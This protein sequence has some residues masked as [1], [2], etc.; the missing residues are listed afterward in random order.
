M[1]YYKRVLRSIRKPQIIII[2]TLTILGLIIRFYALGT[3]SVWYD[4][5]ITSIAARTLQTEGFPVLPSGAQY[6]RGILHTFF[7]ATSYE[8]LG[9]STLAGRLPAMVL[10]TLSIP[11]SYLIGKR[12]KNKR[13]G[14]LLAF[15][16]TFATVQIAWSRQVRFYQQLQF[17][18]LLSL[19]FF[20]KLLDKMKWHHLIL[21][22]FSIGC[23]TISHDPFGYLLAIPF[24]LWFLVEKSKWFF[25]KVK[26]IKETNLKHRVG[27]ALVI[28]ILIILIVVRSPEFFAYVT[29]ALGNEVDYLSGYLEHFRTQMGGFFVLA[30]PGALLGVLERKRNFFYVFSFLGPL[31]VIS[32]HVLAFQHRYVFM[33]FPLLFAFSALTLDYIFEKLRS[34]ETFQNLFGNEK[35]IPSIGVLVLVLLLLP[36]ATFTFTLESHY[37]LGRTAPQ[38]EFRQ[39]YQHIENNLDEEDVI[40]ST[41]TPVS[42]YYLQQSEYW[43]SFSPWGLKTLPEK[44][45]YTNATTIKH[46]NQ[47]QK[48][49]EN[50]TGW[51]II[52]QMGKRKANPEVLEYIKENHKLVKKVSGQEKRVWV[53][54]F[55]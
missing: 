53:Y 39:A 34:L 4:E 21:V 46:P 23:M 18:F 2:L 41:L 14:L 25:E 26:K 12:L 5:A 51:I 8:I 45:P 40:I 55:S 52:D 43:I 33:L 13:V 1:N 32:N 38:G 19:Y 3:Q 54:K 28:T 30:I 49:S 35:I 15:F 37:D 17:F 22:I 20:E 36:G 29:R 50:E 6:T 42:Y 44:E 47:I 11:L 16:V 31:Y 48:V 24:P 27:G 9:F 7:V 10:G